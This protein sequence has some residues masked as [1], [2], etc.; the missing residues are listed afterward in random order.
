MLMTSRFVSLLVTSSLCL[1]LLGGCILPGNS[2]DLCDPGRSVSCVCPG[3]ANGAQICADDGA[4]FQECICRACTAGDIRSCDCSNGMTGT[5]TCRGDGFGECSCSSDR[6]MTD[7]SSPSSTIDMD[8]P[9]PAEDMEDMATVREDMTPS[10]TPE[11]N[12]S[13]EGGVLS[14]RD[15]CDEPGGLIQVCNDGCATEHACLTRLGFCFEE[16]CPTTCDFL[17]PERES[18]G[19]YAA[20]RLDAPHYPQLSIRLDSPVDI[21]L[22]DEGGGMFG[23]SLQYS[24]TKIA[25]DRSLPIKF[26]RNGGEQ[27]ST[28]MDIG[29][30]IIHSLDGGDLHT[31][32][33]G[34]TPEQVVRVVFAPLD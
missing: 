31:I 9:P 30:G 24:V 3:G 13:C 25:T 16:D 34:P 7:M 29:C 18:T 20:R 23:G 15:S 10:C 12:S 27:E 19:F 6:P 21:V 5:Q 14:W 1:A 28:V 2:D 26:M 4:S 8:S 33:I 32:E 17:D 22:H 11:A